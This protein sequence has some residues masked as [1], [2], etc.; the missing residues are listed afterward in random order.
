MGQKPFSLARGGEKPR[1]AVSVVMFLA[2]VVVLPGRTSIFTVE[3]WGKR[4]GSHVT[5]MYVL[6]GLL[7]GDAVCLCFRRCSSESPGV[8]GAALYG[9]EKPK[10]ERTVVCVINDKNLAFFR[11]AERGAVIFGFLL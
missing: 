6:V 5:G 7:C 4:C 2:V 8:F 10:G 1:G 3:L 11:E 9:R